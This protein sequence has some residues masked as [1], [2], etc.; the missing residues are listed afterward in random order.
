VHSDKED[1]QNMEAKKGAHHPPGD[2]EFQKSQLKE[3]EPDDSRKN[4]EKKK[5]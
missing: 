2:A 5:Y 1:Q 4:H 3:D